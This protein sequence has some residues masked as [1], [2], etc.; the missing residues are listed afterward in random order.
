M[1]IVLDVKVDETAEATFDPFELQDTVTGDIR[2]PYPR[3][4]ELRRQGAVH[5][6]QIDFTGN[7]VPAPP[8]DTGQP[9]PVSV[10]GHDEVVIALRDD[11]TYSSTVYEGI[12]GAVM[13]RTILQM[14][15]PQHKLQR[16]LVSPA[17]RSRV[18]ERWEAGLVR[19]VVDDLI[20]EFA[21]RGHADLVRQLTFGFPVRVIARILGLPM[22]DYSRFQQWTLEL[23]SVAMDWERG[24]AASEALGSYLTAIIDQRR[25]H[26][27]DDLISDLVAADIDGEKLCDEDILA[28]LRL[29]LPAGVETTYRATGNLLFGLLQD[30]DQL[31]AVR[32]DRTL[33]A[34][35]FEESLRWEPPVTMILRRTL[36]DTELGGVAI[37]A[38]SDVGLFLGG[39]NRDERRY[40]DPDEFDIFRQAQQ[41]VGF[42]FGVHM[43]LGMHLARME[44]RVAVNALFDRLDD[45]RL[46]LE[47]DDDPHIH[48]FAFRSPTSLPVSFSAR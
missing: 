40:T 3:M 28:F 44:S 14:D 11:K 46:D 19:S 36:K 45:I 23:I 8:V 33:Y 2:D 26:P 16:A 15:A 9:P 10:L 5:V 30:P 47:P 6:G 25:L 27:A 24:M 39:A 21:G 34:Q 48:G 22:D 38:N 42:G 4:A 17:F 32:N 35:A 20:D 7:E 29:L 41:H 31:N 12:M 13:G 37:P 18:L 43:C 1:S